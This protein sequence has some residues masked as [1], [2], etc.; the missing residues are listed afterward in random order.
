MI[1]QEVECKMGDKF[2][3]FCKHNLGK[4]YPQWMVPC[5]I[6]GITPAEYAKLLV[7]E[8]KA[9][10]A[11]HPETSYMS[12]CWASKADESRWRNYINQQARV[13]GFHI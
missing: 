7:E 2:Y 12:K 10:V 9:I 4:K 5:R 11:W 6:L 1:Y 13:K 8:Y 3:S